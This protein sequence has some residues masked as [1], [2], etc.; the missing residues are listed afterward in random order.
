MKNGEL[1]CKQEA[2]EAE[3]IAPYCGVV[4]YRGNDRDWPYNGL[5]V[6]WKFS[7]LEAIKNYIDKALSTGTQYVNERGA[8]MFK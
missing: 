1:V 8:L 7:S 4:L 3:Y 2:D 6:V 5:G